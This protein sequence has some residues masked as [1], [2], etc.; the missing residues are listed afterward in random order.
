MTFQDPL[1]LPFTIYALPG[2]TC[3][4]CHWPEKFYAQ[5]LRQSKHFLTDSLNTEWN[6][7]LK[8]KI[9]PQH[10]ALGLSEGIHWHINPNIKIEYIP[11]RD[12]RQVIPWV[13]YTNLKTG[14]EKIYIDEDNALDEEKM[15][16]AEVRDMDCMDCHNR[17][18]HHYYTPQEFIDEA[19]VSGEIPKDLP[20]IKKVAMDLFVDPYD[21]KDTALYTIKTYTNEFYSEN[22]PE[23]YAS[24]KR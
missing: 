2:K 13:K 23:L 14:E 1:K 8:M 20:F 19:M 7:H 10:S 17:P 24:K 3:E 12:N 22:Y 4:E 16:E 15:A 11:K 18:S 6:I 21:T 9:G 5:Q